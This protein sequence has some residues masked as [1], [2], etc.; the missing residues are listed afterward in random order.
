MAFSKSTAR[1]LGAIEVPVPPPDE[2]EAIANHLDRVLGEINAA[3]EKLL[4]E[5]KLVEEYRERLIADAVT[6]GLDVRAAALAILADESD[7]EVLPEEDDEATTAED[8]D[9]EDDADV[10]LAEVDE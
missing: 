1:Q 2:Q 3:A 4:R 7:S 6:G 10:A 9:D 8:A 5:I